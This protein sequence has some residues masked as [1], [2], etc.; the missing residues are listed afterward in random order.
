M[1]SSS[2]SSPATPPTRE[3]GRINA[4][5]GEPPRPPP[6]R[7]A[8][9]TGVE[10]ALVADLRADPANL[11]KH[12][13][14]SIDAIKASLLR[15]GQQKPIVVDAK[16]VTVAGAGVLEAAVQLQWSHLDVVRTGLAGT[17]RVAYGIADNR[18]A[19]LSEWDGPALG[20]TLAEL[21]QD[22]AGELGFTE[23][24][25]HTLTMGDEDEAED[26]DVPA[27][28]PKAIAKPGEL[29][30]LGEHRLMCGDSTKI[31]DV[32]RLMGKDKAAMC[33]T[34]PPYLVDYTGKRHA[35]KG[36]K[37]SGKDWSNTYRE[38]DI[39]DHNA[40]F[41][42]VFGCV[43]A[44]LK[45]HAPV[46]CWHADVRAQLILTV[47]KDLGI[48]HHQNVLWVKPA[49]VLA[50]LFWMPRYEPCLMGWVKGSKPQ[51][52]GIVSEGV[53]Q[54][55][56]VGTQ[57]L[58]AMT[59]QELIAHILEGSSVWDVDWEGKARVTGNEHPTQKPVELFARPMRKH[60]RPGAVVYEP[61]SGSGTQLIAAE[62]LGRRCR[63]MEI[64]PVFIDVAIRR[65]QALTGKAATL[66]GTGQTWDEARAARA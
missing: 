45:P 35:P 28:A 2:G 62:G 15:F 1:R 39:T 58:E 65:W 42:G 49:P 54:R 17:D 63:A 53:W 7:T 36:K 41:R 60:T 46:Y 56:S 18:S 55:P 38:I 8:P 22:L 66:E 20:L 9:T 14:R 44:V 23:E 24:E 29:W 5:R 19:E 6:P 64:E 50:R 52:D 40:F 3:G 11:R 32:Q 59:K 13:P 47:W 37:I 57:D 26:D 30:H 34:D 25:I 21:G 12:G 48:L 31:E 61:F 33:A 27:P 4:C 16:G 51:H 43:K 10:R